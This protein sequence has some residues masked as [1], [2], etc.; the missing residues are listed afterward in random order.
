MYEPQGSEYEG[1]MTEK[2]RRIKAW[3]SMGPIY[4]EL[5][6]GD[7]TY[8]FCARCNERPARGKLCYVCLMKG[9]VE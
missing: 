2:E 9:V 7:H 3:A 8:H 1:T 4:H 6:P 5:A